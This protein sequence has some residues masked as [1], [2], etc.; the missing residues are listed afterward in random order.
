MSFTE[1]DVRVMLAELRETCRR[2]RKLSMVWKAVATHRLEKRNHL[3]LREKLSAW[4]RS[5]G[6]NRCNVYDGQCWRP[7]SYGHVCLGDDPKHSQI[8]VDFHSRLS[9]TP[10]GTTAS[11]WAQV[12][13]YCRAMDRAVARKDDRAAG[14]PR[15]AS[16]GSA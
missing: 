8:D 10:E 5:H 13:R 1:C 7:S 9:A 11:M 3:R 12:Q 4:R 16:G 15:E 14:R 2:V 6:S